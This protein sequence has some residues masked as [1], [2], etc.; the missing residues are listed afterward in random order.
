MNLQKYI[1]HIVF[2]SSVITNIY[3]VEDP[4]TA[5]RQQRDSNLIH[6]AYIGNINEFNEL[7]HNNANPNATNIAGETPLIIAAQNGFVEIA[8]SALNNGANVLA[9][10][11]QGRNAQTH[12]E[13][14][15]E[16]NQRSQLNGAHNRTAEFDTIITML[17]Q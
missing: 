16:S 1:Y 5:V 3:S 9:A 14:A 17:R 11:N 10:D 13:L 7:L 12:A 15:R 2:V 6:A 8:Q 4:E